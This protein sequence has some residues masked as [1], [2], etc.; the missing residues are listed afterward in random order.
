MCRIGVLFTEDDMGQLIYFPGRGAEKPADGDDFEA[1][2]QAYESAAQQL[3][4]IGREL[5][6]NESFSQRRLDEVCS[7]IGNATATLRRLTP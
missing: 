1:A 6:E 4:A 3:R 7:F 2:A 5:T